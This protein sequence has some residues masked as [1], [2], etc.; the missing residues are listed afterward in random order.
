MR[1]PQTNPFLEILTGSDARTV[2]PPIRSPRA[3]RVVPAATTAP[4]S[5]RLHVVLPHPLV[6]KLKALAHE[7]RQPLSHL[8]AELVDHALTHAEAARGEPLP[9]FRGSLP[10]G[11][12]LT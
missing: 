11:R 2:A 7:R 9:L 12:P 6:P 1:K 8:V 10:P 3:G 4:L 5:A